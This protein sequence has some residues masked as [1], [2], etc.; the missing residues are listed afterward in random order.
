M[1]SLYLL[2]PSF[3]LSPCSIFPTLHPLSIPPSPLLDP[4]PGHPCPS[5]PLLVV[6]I[7]DEGEDIGGARRCSFFR[8]PGDRPAPEV[9]RR[10][11]HGEKAEM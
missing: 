5:R 4:S 8:R 2:D 1:E 9:P 7:A 10:T 3:A 6:L 11:L